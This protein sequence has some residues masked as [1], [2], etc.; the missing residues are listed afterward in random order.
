MGLD[1]VRT[2]FG[3]VTSALGG[4]ATYF[5]AAAGLYA[6]VNL[7]SIVG[8]DFPQEHLD[9]LASRDVD[10]TGL[11][12]ANGATFRWSGSY[13][14]DLNA[15]ETLDTQLNVVESFDPVLPKEYR[16]TP[17]VF[18]ANG[19]P[20]Q[21]ARVLDQLEAPR[22]TVLDTMNLWIETQR[23]DLI[24]VIGRVDMVTVNEGEARLLARTP[25][26][27]RAAR[28]ILS[29]GPKAVLIKRGEAGAVMFASDS[30]FVAPAYPLEEVYD[31]TGAGDSF[32][33]GFMGYLAREGRVEADTLKRAVIHG[34]AVASY[35][36]EA[37]SLGRLQMLTVREVEDRYSEFRYFTQ[38]EEI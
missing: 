20:L 9:F 32:A 37:F 34:S 22:L 31:P 24:D 11:Q 36:V 12:R 6:P 19:P 23:S 14:A 2:P 33:G 7:V 38:F 13:E 17:F 27:V 28:Q 8:S 4:S 18:L 10:L 1:D 16:A 25:S 15:A 21:Q 26:L 35:T 5:S 29:L 30:Y 3:E